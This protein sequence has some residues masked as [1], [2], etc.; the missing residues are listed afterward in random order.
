[1]L[2]LWNRMAGLIYLR[3]WNISYEHNR[4]HGENSLDRYGLDTGYMLSFNFN[5]K[6]EPGVQRVQLGDKVMFEGT[7]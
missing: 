4:I 3:S 5:R 1:M 6:K 2:L 7:V